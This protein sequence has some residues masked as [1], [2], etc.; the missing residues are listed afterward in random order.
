[1]RFAALSVLTLVSQAVELTKRNK[2]PKMSVDD[3]LEMFDKTGDRIIHKDEFED[4]LIAY[5]VP[6]KLRTTYMEDFD[7]AD[8]DNSGSVDVAELEASVDAL[9]QIASSVQRSHRD[10]RSLAEKS[11]RP[12]RSLAQIKALMHDDDMQE[13]VD[14][15]DHDNDGSIQCD[16]FV[17]TIAQIAAWNDVSLSAEDVKALHDEFV[18]T[19]TDK[20]GLV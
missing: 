8:K 1:M 4:G 16:E 10:S 20:D 2:Q 9:A 6:T 13:I 19:D 18:E 7:K 12:S 17:G 5:G 15:F 14:A 11:H 3:I